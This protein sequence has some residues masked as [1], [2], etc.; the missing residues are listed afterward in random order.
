[1]F[2]ALKTSI[3]TGIGFAAGSVLVV[4]VVDTYSNPHKRA[5]FIEEAGKLA[6]KLKRFYS[7]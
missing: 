1:M 4:K 7:A 2:N 5:L 3:V 6:G